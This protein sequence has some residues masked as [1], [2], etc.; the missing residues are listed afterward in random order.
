[1][2]WTLAPIVN[3]LL[4]SNGWK[5]LLDPSVGQGTVGWPKQSVD[6]ER[7]GIRYCYDGRYCWMALSITKSHETNV[8]LK[9]KGVPS[10]VVRKAE[11]KQFISCFCFTVVLSVL[12]ILTT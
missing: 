1:M 8:P 10:E 9:F 5:K 4:N 6:Q 3:A 11:G 2:Q 7:Y 12:M